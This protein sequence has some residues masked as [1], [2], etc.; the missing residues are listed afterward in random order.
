MMLT[1]EAEFPVRTLTL[2]LFIPGALATFVGILTE[3]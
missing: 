3:S 1:I 2:V